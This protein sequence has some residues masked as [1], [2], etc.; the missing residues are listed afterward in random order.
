MVYSLLWVM[1]DFVHQP[2]EPQNIESKPESWNMGLG[3]LVLGS[4]ILYLKGMRRMMFQLSGF[5]CR[6]N[7]HPYQHPLENRNQNLSTPQ[8]HHPNNNNVNQTAQSKPAS[9]PAPSTL[10]PKPS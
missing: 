2:Y 1:Q 3:G 10:N 9:I 7:Q 8:L 5:Y 4:L 6:V